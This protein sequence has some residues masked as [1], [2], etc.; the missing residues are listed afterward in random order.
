MK[1]FSKILLTAA[2]AAIITFNVKVMA[3]AKNPAQELAA[4]LQQKV[5]LNDNQVKK[6]ET[7]I[8]N[9]FADASKSK[10]LSD[11]VKKLM[12]EKQAA[13]FEIVKEDWLKDLDK[14]KS[15]SN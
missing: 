10:E 2:I 3:Q 5:L 11:E 6:V 13:K 8:N 14:A 7:L 1:K 9:Y 12:D 15:K 4:K